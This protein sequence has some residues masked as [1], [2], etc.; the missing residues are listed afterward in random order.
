MEY[1]PF[2]IQNNRDLDMQP[3]HYYVPVVVIHFHQSELYIV[4]QV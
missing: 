1:V 2:F 4:L 3:L